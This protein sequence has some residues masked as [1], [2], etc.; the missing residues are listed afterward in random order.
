MPRLYP[1]GSLP[2][3]EKKA[4]CN[5]AYDEHVRVFSQ[6]EEPEA[7]AAVFRMETGDKLGFRFRDIERGAVGFRRRGDEV[8]EACNGLEKDKPPRCAGRSRYPKSSR[9]GP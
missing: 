4:G 8:D 5:G 9:N 7:H 3:A 1:E 6:E 2:S